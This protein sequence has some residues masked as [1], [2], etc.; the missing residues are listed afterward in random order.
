[1]PLGSAVGRRG[2]I[3]VPLPFSHPPVMLALQVACD[4]VLRCVTDNLKH[5]ALSATGFG[6]GP[7]VGPC[8]A[9]AALG[10]GSESPYAL[11]AEI[12]SCFDIGDGGASQ[13]YPRFL[14]LRAVR[15]DFGFE[16]CRDALVNGPIIQFLI[17][18]RLESM[19]G[20]PHSFV[21]CA[22]SRTCVHG[23]LILKTKR[24]NIKQVRNPTGPSH[25][26][27]TSNVV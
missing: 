27:Q 26:R 9:A 18:F 22:R 24:L 5:S 17:L 23:S 11:I 1:M 20:C 14:P 7:A 21:D 13:S 4:A 15:Q 12:R 6:H 8:R 10:L 3:E 19:R 16:M 25:H 2:A